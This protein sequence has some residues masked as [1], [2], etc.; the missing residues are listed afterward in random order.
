MDSATEFL[1]GQCA[2]SLSASL[3]YPHN[4]SP[5]PAM[6][7]STSSQDADS[8]PAAFAEVM[9][10]IAFRERV[11][12]VWP[13]FEMFSDRTAKPMKT[14]DKFLDP[15]IRSAVERKKRNKRDEV[16]AFED[17]D[18]GDDAT[19]LDELLKSTTGIYPLFINKN[20]L[21]S[22]LF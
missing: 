22:I 7:D 16:P 9:L 8:F 14:V 13:L 6:E 17:G 4:V 3:P 15:I 5:I 11:G 19:L 2:N 12:W 10:Q 18:T 21:M 20:L 1:F